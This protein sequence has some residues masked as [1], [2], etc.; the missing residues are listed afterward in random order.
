MSRIVAVC[1]GGDWADAS[2]DHLM[3]PDDMD[4]DAELRAHRVWLNSVYTPAL[5]AGNPIAYVNFVAWLRG[6]GASDDTPVEIYEG[7]L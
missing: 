7:G 6:R 5:R 4:L 1:G 2:V 3:V